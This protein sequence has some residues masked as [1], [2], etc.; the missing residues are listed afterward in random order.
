MT[1]WD[2]MTDKVLEAIHNIPTYSDRE[3]VI[4]TA[5]LIYLYQSLESEEI[6]N[7]NI[8]TLNREKSK[9]KTR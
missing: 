2:I 6:F 8:E 1:E 5:V 4:K 9:R 7:D 3:Q